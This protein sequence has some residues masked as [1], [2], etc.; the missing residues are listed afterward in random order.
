MKI[1]TVCGMGFGTSMML[2]MQVRDILA[3]EGVQA[4]VDPVDLGSFKSMQAD[5]VIAPRDMES[6]VTAGPAEHVVLIDN[7]V[8]R[9]EVSS[10]VLEL[11][12]SLAD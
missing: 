11:L 2:A 12:R 3:D 4:S 1:A 9:D 7:L 5:V 6:Q 8:D 10:K